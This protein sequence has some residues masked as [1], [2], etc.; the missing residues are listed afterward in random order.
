VRARAA[1]DL[2][3]MLFVLTSLPVFLQLNVGK[4]TGAATR[5]LI[6]AAADD[7]V[8]RAGKKRPT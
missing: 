6:L 1:A 3:D 7:A 5:K 8:L 2:V 4:R